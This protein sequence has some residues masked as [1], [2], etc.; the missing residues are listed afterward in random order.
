ML[1]DMT[2]MAEHANSLLHKAALVPTPVSC[3]VP[4]PPPPSSYTE[5]YSAEGFF[6]GVRSTV[7]IQRSPSIVYDSLSKDLH[8]VFTP[9]TVQLLRV[10]H[11]VVPHITCLAS[12]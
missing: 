8:H 1:L 5:P 11:R 9:I 3:F 7:T 6:T 2:P 10:A 4:Q 12:L